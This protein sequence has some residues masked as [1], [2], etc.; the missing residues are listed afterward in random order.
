[1]G[2]PLRIGLY[3]PFFGSTLGGGEKYLGVAAEA[4]RD[5]FPQAGVEL[6]TPVPVDVARYERML[7]LDLRGIGFRSLYPRRMP[8][9]GR[10]AR[11]PMLR[12]YRDLLVS[13][14][15]ARATAEYD[16]LVSMVYVL[17]AFSRA[18]RGVILCQ[19][20][21][22]RRSAGGRRGVPP[23]AY[24]LYTNLYEA[25]RRRLLGGEVDDFQLVICQSEYVRTW[26]RRLWNRDS[27]VVHP[28]I[29]VPESELDW[30]RKGNLIVSVGRFF[31][32]GHNKR[33]DV[34][35]QAFRDLCDGGLEGWELH[36]AGSVHQSTSA[37]IEYL[38]RVQQLAGGY[39]VR[40]HLDAPREEVQRLY[41]E[42]AVYWH[43]AGLGVDPEARPAELEH[44]GMTTVE[45]MAAG[46]VP[47]VIA[48]GGQREVV[49]D[50][51]TGYLWEDLATLKA[52]TLALAADAEQ[53]RRLGEAARRASARFSRHEFEQQMVEALR[54][55][56]QELKAAVAG[57]GAI[58]PA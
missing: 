4:L 18:R 15:A 16:L 14:Q 8:G 38:E 35:V 39:P 10:L 58:A 9:R 21:Y 17:P 20:P 12:R 40:L 5:A 49:E 36:L 45:A 31:A 52:R 26:V 57:A 50:G 27:L 29:D 30:S 19:F 44:F 24:R 48:R 41:Q 37:D 54:P 11:V 13:V 2:R 46:A 51:A 23:F 33:H 47:V 42:A 1:V 56:V 28:P 22:G 7:G 53:R 43:A 34:L 6:F 55:L 25:L 3:S 32:G